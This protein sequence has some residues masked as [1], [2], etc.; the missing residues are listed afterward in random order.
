M[1][2]E[3][4]PTIPK[5]ADRAL[6]GTFIFLSAALVLVVILMFVT[7]SVVDDLIETYTDDAPETLPRETISEESMEDLRQRLD[8]FSENTED[9]VQERH[10]S[11]SETDINALIQDHLANEA[12]QSGEEVATNLH[13][14]FERG[15]VRTN[16]SVRLP[17]DFATGYLSKLNG[18][19]VNGVA[20][21]EVAVVNGELDVRL[22]SF[23][24]GNESLPE[25][26][27]KKLWRDLEMSGFWERPDVKDFFSTI[28]GLEIVDG[29]A[30]L[31]K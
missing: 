9:P 14:R 26:A 23:D 18:R 1:H 20:T 25:W 24:V 2:E 27:L 10:L 21:T 12:K 11:L 30:I 19:Y 4:Q 29:E 31:Y 16:L 22:S 17:H 15:S 8:A 5:W 7:R 13:V 28:E 6:V 3:K